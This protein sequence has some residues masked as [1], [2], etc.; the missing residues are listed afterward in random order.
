[1]HVATYS[2]RIAALSREHAWER[3]ARVS[4]AVATVV[5]VALYAV[6]VSMSIVNVIAQREA[7]RDQSTASAS[8]ASLEHEYFNASDAIT[9]SRAETL[10]LTT[11]ESTHY[12]TRTTRLGYAGGSGDV[13]R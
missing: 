4:L 5:L 9:E 6:L 10:G 7:L 2:I 12:V 11:V 13:V 3:R 1:M 8:I